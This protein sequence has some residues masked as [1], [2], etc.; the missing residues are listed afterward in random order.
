LAVSCERRA[1]TA[2]TAESAGMAG[3]SRLWTA[4]FHA[5]RKWGRAETQ[6][7]LEQVNLYEIKR[8]D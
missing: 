4:R 3:S 7:R 5:R 6:I 2:V 8:R 1:G